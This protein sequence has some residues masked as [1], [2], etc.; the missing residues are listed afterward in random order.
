MR[1]NP[2]HKA[3][4]NQQLDLDKLVWQVLLAVCW[5]HPGVVRSPPGAVLP[6]SDPSHPPPTRSHNLIQ[7]LTCLS[8]NPNSNTSSISVN[9]GI[10]FSSAVS[11]SRSS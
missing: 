5:E 10:S 8:F 4:Q 3:Q 6:T 2:A 7:L 1:D 11:I 9:F